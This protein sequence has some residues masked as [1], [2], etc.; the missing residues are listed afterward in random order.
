LGSK[1]L[2]V[3]NGSTTFA[4]VIQDG[5]IG[6]GTAGKLTVS[7][8]TETLTGTNTYTG[9]TTITA[10][11]LAL[12]TGGSIATSSDV[13]DNATFDI[14]Q[15]T[16]G[17]SIITLSGTGT[18]SL[19]SKALTITNGSTTF[20]GVIANGGI[21]G[22]TAGTVTISGG[23]ETLTGTNTYTGATSIG[24]G[25]TLA[26]SSTGSIATSLGVTDTG[27]LDI[28]NTSS[29]ASITT[30]GGAGTVT[31]GGKFLTITNGAAG[32][33]GLTPA[34]VFSGSIGGSGGLAITGGH[35]ELT[36]T[37]TYTG[38]TTVINATLSINSGASLG[39][40]SGPL[41]L[42]NSTLV[43][44][45]NLTTSRPVTLLGIDTLNTGNYS[46]GLSG[47]VS[48]S[49]SLYVDGTGTLTLSGTNT[50]TGGIT[51]ASGA[52]LASTSTAALGSDPLSYVTPSNTVVDAFTGTAHVLGPL[53]LVNGSQT[54]IY[55]SSIN[56]L[57]GVGSV[58]ANVIV[59][60]GG[61]TAPGDGPGTITISGAVTNLPGSTFQVDVD[62]SAS[63]IGCPSMLGCA[64]TYSSLVLTGAGGVYTAGGL[65][66]P[67]LRG[68]DPPANNT[69][70]PTLGT[71]FLVVQAAGGVLGSYS[72]LTQ[73]SSGLAA[74]TRFDTLFYSNDI[75]L[76]VTPVTFKNVPGMG[77]TLNG[78]Q[79]QVAGAID[80]LR[81]PAG[82]RNNAGATQ[83]LA[84]LYSLPA[85]SL[86]QAYSTLSGEVAT[87]AKFGAFKMT[88][89]FL[90]L[91]SDEGIDGRDHKAP[92]GPKVWGSVFGL[93][94]Q[95]KGDTLQGSNNVSSQAE[96]VAF[97][98]EYRFNSNFVAGVAGAGGAT[99]WSLSQSLGSGSTAG[100][101]LAAYG[102][103]QSDR[104]YVSASGE[105]GFHDASTDRYALSLE[106]IKSKYTAQVYGGRL[107][108][109]YAFPVATSVT[110]TPYAALQS[111]SYKTPTYSEGDGAGGAFGLTFNGQTSSDTR[112]E[113]GARFD[114]K[115]ATAAAPL[116]L[117]LRTGWAHEQFDGLSMQATFNPALQA[118][119]APGANT[120]FVVTG[121]K[122]AKD[123]ALLSLS[124]KMQASK[125]LTFDVNFDGGEFA[126]GSS[127][128]GA[129]GAIRFH[130]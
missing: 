67:I 34:G 75:E 40:A 71:T 20:G 98:A 105:F 107:E 11:T 2:T 120:A 45:N 55:V 127:N 44:D 99:G 33:S 112:T 68:I 90:S 7:G 1:I 124:A 111:Q 83:D 121:A 13:I 125:H 115:V 113:L 21:G 53:E 54:D 94:G 43:A 50:S 36:G 37:S 88:T 58:N 66:A 130:W 108:A 101:M 27:T 41:T 63:S 109:G 24:S 79:N 51:V 16:T 80:A 76:V 102:G 46:V 89:E 126:N 103:W 100:Y 84:I 129:S 42:N 25:A 62:G 22:G 60:N 114:A 29:G 8:G 95:N 5:G 77:V 74:G 15:T 73:P 48:G 86:P 72:S 35:Q 61:L 6:G 81:G 38:G 32:S 47:N 64:G 39:A 18:A 117:S 82:P 52:T 56:S 31:L 28:S 110:I 92:I 85:T 12:K 104:A 59:Q 19:G 10:G 70:T 78:N 106:H 65:I 97:G 91:I 122:P 14:S 23:T 57:V 17:A 9:V 49:G 128:Y 118:G 30:L 87:G 119:A 26:L 93:G 96:G 116:L 69:Y 123:A 4:G 3:T